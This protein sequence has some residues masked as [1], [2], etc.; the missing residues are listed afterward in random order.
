MT[1][2]ERLLAHAISP[3]LVTYIPGCATKRFAKDM[4]FAAEHCPD[5]VLTDKQR[6]YLFDTVHRY[7]RQIPPAIVNAA[8]AHKEQP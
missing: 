5:T 4:E 1:D 3:A 2:L 6:K 8:A 7:R